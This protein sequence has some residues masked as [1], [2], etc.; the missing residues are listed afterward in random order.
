MYNLLVVSHSILRWA[1]VVS[2]VITFFLIVLNKIKQNPFPILIK[3]ASLVTLIILHMQFLF[4][5]LLF[6]TSPKVIFSGLAMKAPLTRFFLVEHSTAMILAIILITIGYIKS[7]KAMEDHIKYNTI[8]IYYL[9]GFVIIL[10][11]IP[12][13]FYN[14]GTTWF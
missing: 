12:W 2:F 5:L 1:I 3:K 6:F 13:P 14:F 7:K 9:I 11:A 8:I 10:A 4:G